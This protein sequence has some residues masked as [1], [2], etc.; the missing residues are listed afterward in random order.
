MSVV[1]AGIPLIVLVVTCVVTC[2]LFVFLRDRG[3]R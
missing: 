3:S 2:W 1:D